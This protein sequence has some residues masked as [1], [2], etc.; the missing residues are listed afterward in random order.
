[1]DPL[2]DTGL[3]MTLSTSTQKMGNI[4]GDDSAASAV[5]R[6]CNHED[7][8][9]IGIIIGLLRT[10]MAILYGIEGE[11]ER[12]ID[13][14]KGAV[15][16]HRHQ[17]ALKHASQIFDDVEEL[18]GLMVLIIDR[19]DNAQMCLEDHKE[20]LDKI[21]LYSASYDATE[22]QSEVTSPK[23]IV[24]EMLEKSARSDESL[25]EYDEDALEMLS[26]HTA[27]QDKHDDGIM[28]LSDALQIL[29]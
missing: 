4:F 27:E 11:Y 12:A 15:Q 23:Q 28:Y 20:L 29:E 6:K 22:I 3:C 25:S 17:P 13:L 10:K 18:S 2:R 16:V 8:R 21:D 26:V 14:C 24:F 9:I 7:L 19:L 1:M 5:I